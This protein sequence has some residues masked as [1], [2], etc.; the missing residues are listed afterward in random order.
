MKSIKNKNFHRIRMG[1][2]LINKDVYFYD[3]EEKRFKYIINVS[4]RFNLNCEPRYIL[5]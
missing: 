5:K 1:Q 3:W 4:L 2:L